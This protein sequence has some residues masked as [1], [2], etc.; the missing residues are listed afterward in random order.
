MRVFPAVLRSS[1]QP[2]AEPTVGIWLL[3]LV[4]AGL[5]SSGLLGDALTTDVDL[6]NNPEAKQAQKLLEERLRG[7][8]RPTAAWRTSGRCPTPGAPDDFP[9]LVGLFAAGNTST[10]PSWA[11]RT[12]F[13]IRC[14]LGELL[15]WD[16]P[17]SGVGFRV[18]TLRHR[19]RADLRDAPAG[20]SSTSFPSDRSTC[21]T[22][23]GRQRWPTGRCT[24]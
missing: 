22:R 11:A 16:D 6:L 12:R 23:S 17:D 20:R 4:A 18:L 3:D 19:F 13:T 1:Q 10:N 21:R 24:P 8:A 14:K 15:G 9:R 2:S 7:P 5:L